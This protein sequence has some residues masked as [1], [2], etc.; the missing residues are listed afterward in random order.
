MKPATIEKS[1]I[2]SFIKALS[3]DYEVVGPRRNGAANEFYFD[4]VTSADELALDYDNTIIPPKKYLLPACET[5]LRF[6]RGRPIPEYPVLERRQVIFGIRPCD[7]TSFLYLDKV[8]SSHRTD[9]RYR[10]RRDNLLT[11][12]ISCTQMCEGSFCTSM[13]SGPRPRVGFDL[14]LTDVGRRYLVEIGSEEGARLL[15]SAV[16]SPATPAD[17]AGKQRILSRLEERRSL[18]FEAGELP[19]LIKR[20]INNRIW[21]EIGERCLACS[22]CAMVC[23]TCFCFD[24]RDRTSPSLERVERCRTW[25]VCLNAEFSAVA[26][27]GNFRRERKDRLRQ[28]QAHNL[29]YS[30][31]QFGTPKC[32]G[33]GRCTRVCPV[34]IDI[35]ETIRELKRGS[36]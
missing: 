9:P 8:Y 7:L 23:P 29:G 5:L 10:M 30:N 17:L 20:G 6:E 19:G 14:L 27:G 28:F 31:E 33:C 34:H 1:R 21:A 13:G 35:R 4:R 3:K 22:Q 32:V 15:S 12:V 25:D 2:G 26:M 36:Q 24:I 16:T 18:E 11:I